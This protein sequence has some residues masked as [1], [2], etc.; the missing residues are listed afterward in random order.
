MV[1]VRLRFALLGQGIAVHYS[2]RV[3]VT[4]R[5]RLQALSK[6]K[7]IFHSPGFWESKIKV[8]AG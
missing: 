7:L 3:V 5:H 1:E 8:S 6:Q 4:E 2:V